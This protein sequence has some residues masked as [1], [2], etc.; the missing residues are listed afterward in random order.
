MIY[1]VWHSETD[2]M[3]GSVDIPQWVWPAP[4]ARVTVKVAQGSFEDRDG[5]KWGAIQMSMFRITR[6]GG[7]PYWALETNL[8]REL[9]TK[10]EGF[11]PAILMPRPTD[12]TYLQ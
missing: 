4:D 3:V 2:E 12:Y 6:Q 5:K 8:P 10:L 9:L 1:E 7:D 11:I